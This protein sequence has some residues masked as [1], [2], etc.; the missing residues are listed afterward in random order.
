MQSCIQRELKATPLRD[1]HVF[2]T[3]KEDLGR[4]LSLVD[5]M[6]PLHPCDENYAN[7]SMEEEGR[8]AAHVKWDGKTIALGT[9]CAA[10]AA[11]K[12]E[13]A[14]ALT[15]EWR[16]TMVPKPD[17]KWVKQALERLGIRVVNDRPGRRKKEQVIKEREEK[18]KRKLM[19]SAGDQLYMAASGRGFPA[20]SSVDQSASS[21]VASA[22]GGY[23]LMA[24]LPDSATNPSSLGFPSSLPGSNFPNIANSSS[25][26]MQR[27]LSNDIASFSR[28]LSNDRSAFN[29]N[30]M[31]YD[32]F[33]R[34]SFQGLPSQGQGI[35]GMNNPMSNL[36]HELGHV[37]SPSRRHYQVLKEHHDNLLKEL[38]QTTYMMEM[39]QNCNFEDEQDNS[40]MLGMNAMLQ[41]PLHDV[42]M[43]Q[44]RAT[45]SRRMSLGMNNPSLG[46][47][48]PYDFATS[49]R[50]DSLG[51]S[52]FQSRRDSLAEALSGM[53]SMSH[54]MTRPSFNQNAQFHLQNP[55]MINQGSYGGQGQ[56]RNLIRDTA[57]VTDSNRRPTGSS[58]PQSGAKRTKLDE[59]TGN[60][61]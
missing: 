28:R 55:G 5:S 36:S 7:S 18:Q 9:F 53:N 31:G 17:V 48:L 34:S 30:T 41:S 35:T 37:P 32:E 40:G 61:A 4:R 15:K 60:K 45:F 49:Q 20:A 33:S 16:A 50:R 43:D 54:A 38:Q 46:T 27:R 12:C 3:I 22:S 11:E 2:H 57:N 56:G 59:N 8:K 51:L 47:A 6:E 23:S 52:E 44:R 19:S 1:L 14:K 21:Q 42:N 26:Q 29:A 25:H 13:R 10:E 39:Y 58:D 24:G